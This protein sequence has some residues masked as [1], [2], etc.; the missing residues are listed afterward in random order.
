MPIIR[1]LSISVQDKDGNKY[2]IKTEK[3]F[4]EFIDKLTPEEYEKWKTSYRFTCI[5]NKTGNIWYSGTLRDL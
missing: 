4:Q 2:E 3:E 5:H 1:T